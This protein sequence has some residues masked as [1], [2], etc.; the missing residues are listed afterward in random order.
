MSRDSFRFVGLALFSIA[1]AIG[2]GAAF[3][4]LTT[5][6]FWVDELFTGWVVGGNDGLAGVVERALTDL[7][8][9]LYYIVAYAISAPF[10]STDLALRLPSAVFAVSGVIVFLLTTRAA[11]SLPARFFAAAIATTSPFWFYQAQNARSYA[12]GLLIGAG[13]LALSLQLLA[14]RDRRRPPL[15]VALLFVLIVL[16]ALTHFYLAFVGLAAL[17]ALAAL[18]QWR[19]TLLSMF[20][21]VLVLLGG[22]VEFVVGPHSQFLMQGSWV[23]SNFN[24][25]VSQLGGVRRGLLDRWGLVAIGVCAV[26]L[27]WRLARME[28]PRLASAFAAPL[29]VTGVRS[30][31]VRSDP[32]LLFLL[33]VPVIVIAGAIASS[34]LLAPNFAE[35]NLMLL[36]PFFWAA[37]AK[38]YDLS[39]HQLPQRLALAANLLLGIVAMAMS[40]VALDRDLPRNTP[41]REAAAWIVGHESC[42]GE[43][44]LLVDTSAT[45]IT[46]P[47]FLER[48]VPATRARYIGEFAPLQL[49]RLA[50]VASVEERAL[51]AERL[52]DDG[53]PIL[54]WSVDSATRD[55]SAQAIQDFARWAGI[56]SAASRIRVQF[57]P[58]Y[59][60]ARYSRE[61]ISTTGLY[62]LYVGD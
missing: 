26:L 46:R 18:T 56:E 57:F 49:V 25:Y 62:V 24:W 50:H 42:R 37:S 22:Y 58:E 32:F 31:I 1:T 35:R 14:Q 19:V 60:Y 23:Q 4:G 40:S 3:V 12:L 27:A 33:A 53:C 36:A 29:S 16:G 21:A 41:F 17:L 11:F 28:R 30:L 13:I 10:G 38:L 20:A 15:G 5:S 55:A 59:A 47:G 51:L 43:S 61:N 8:P 48:V 6:S 44:I 54:A 45:I 7:H 34:V 2:L 9:P 52:S 39:F